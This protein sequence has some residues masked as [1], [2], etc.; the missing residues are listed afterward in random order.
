MVN[1]KEGIK[2]IKEI[3][4]TEK[5]TAIECGSGD[6]SVYATPAMI[7]LMENVSKDCVLPFLEEGYTTVGI[8]VDVKHIKATPLGM[9]VKCEALL[10]KIEGKKLFFQ[11]KAWDEVGDVGIGTHERYIVE[12]EGF[13]NKVKQ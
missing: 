12:K 1:V 13:M 9:K 10:T 11:V 2:N 4:V 7:A 5:L 6:L 8:S 3:K